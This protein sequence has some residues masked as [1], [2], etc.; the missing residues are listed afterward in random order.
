MRIRED[1]ELFKAGLLYVI[2]ELH[3]SH[4]IFYGTVPE[5]IMEICSM[6][7]VKVLHFSSEFALSRKGVVA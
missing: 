5:D 4:I 2:S 1:K 3:P 6:R 7:N